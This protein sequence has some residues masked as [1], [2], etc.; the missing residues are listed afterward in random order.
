MG[1]DSE[2]IMLR[3]LGMRFSGVAAVAGAAV[4][5][6]APVQNHCQVPCGI[7]DDPLR[8]AQ[9]KEEATTI[10]KATA[11]VKAAEEKKS[12]DSL[13]HINQVTR[14][15]L[16]KEEHASKIITLVAEYL[17]CQRVK[18]GAF[19]NKEDYWQALEL[20]HALMQAAM[21]TK[22][23]LDPKACDDLDHL[24]A[25]VGAMYTKH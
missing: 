14:W 2:S 25:D 10:R 12:E 4:L 5:A 11:Q 21:K 20:H 15:I 22:Q 9:L 1:K 13:Q 23:T 8:V 19:K 6:Q 18:A 17:L 3:A 16:T 24:I 7:F